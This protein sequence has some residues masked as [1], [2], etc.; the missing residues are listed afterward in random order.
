M[1]IY[2]I[3]FSLMIN[4]FF[5]VK[6]VYIFLSQEERY[7]F[8][9]KIYS[10]CCFICVQRFVLIGWSNHFHTYFKL[11]NL[12]SDIYVNIKKFNDLNKLKYIRVVS[13][14]RY[15]TF[16]CGVTTEKHVW[17]MNRTQ[18]KKKIRDKTRI[19]FYV[20]DTVRW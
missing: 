18:K 14:K 1:L 12:K 5:F 9:S 19:Q 10:T 7:F 4:R 8:Y 6:I 13:T 3:V 15:F 20:W 2:F 17:K 16:I 11:I